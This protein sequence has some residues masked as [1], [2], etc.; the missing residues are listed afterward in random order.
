MS[1][2]RTVSV[3]QV[4]AMLR[5]GEVFAFF[6]VREEGEFSIKGHPLFATCPAPWKPNGHRWASSSPWQSHLEE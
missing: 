3:Q 6:D 4:K 2:D 5:S 1:V